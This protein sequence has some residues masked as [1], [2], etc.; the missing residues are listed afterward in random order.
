MKIENH[1]LLFHFGYIFPTCRLIVPSPWLQQVQLLSCASQNITRLYR[2][3]KADVF[4]LNKIIY[5]GEHHGGKSVLRVFTGESVEGYLLLLFLK[6][7]WWRIW[8]E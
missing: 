4:E 3:M 2:G 7:S 1:N 5:N 8:E 6:G